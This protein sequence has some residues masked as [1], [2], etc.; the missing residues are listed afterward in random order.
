MTKQV[1]ETVFINTLKNRTPDA[2]AWMSGNAQYPN[3]TGIVKFFSIPYKGVLVEAEISGLPDSP[4]SGS[5]D[6][7][8]MHIHENGDCTLPFDRT[9]MHYNPANAPHPQHAGD[10]VPLMGNHGYAWLAFY[11]SRVSISE[12]RGRSV[13]IHRMPDDFITQPAGNSGDKI[14]CGVIQ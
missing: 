12:I 2:M 8:A 14:G 6:F 10:M 1:P 4:D 13:V 11:D 9:G 7:Y 3:L 5:S